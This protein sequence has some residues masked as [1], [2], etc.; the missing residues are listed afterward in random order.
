MD[1]QHLAG[2][3]LNV[4]G[5]IPADLHS[6]KIAGVLVQFLPQQLTACV[7]QSKAHISFLPLAFC[8]NSA[9]VKP[10]NKLSGSLLH[11][12]RVTLLWNLGDI[13]GEHGSTYTERNSSN[14]GSAINKR[15]YQKLTGN[16]F[17]SCKG[18]QTGLE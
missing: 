8:L 6:V 10:T 14:E 5:K 4:C 7:V 16:Q 11:F 1:R 12:F 3:L 15:N 9:F 18:L 2:L 13:S 17:H